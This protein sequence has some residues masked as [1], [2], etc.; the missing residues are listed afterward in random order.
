MEPF[1]R[2]AS[3]IDLALFV[4]GVWTFIVFLLDWPWWVSLI[5]AV[6]A[7]VLAGIF[8]WAQLTRWRLGS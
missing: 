3:W 7:I 6:A 4:T 5:V 1:L 2:W 8:V